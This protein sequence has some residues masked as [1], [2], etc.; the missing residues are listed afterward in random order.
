MAWQTATAEQPTIDNLILSWKEA[1]AQLDAVKAKEATI[2]A[3]LVAAAFPNAKEGVNT[4]ELGNGWQLKATVK[5]NYNLDKKN[6]D[7][8]IEKIEET[9]EDGKFV[10]ERLVTWKPELSIREYRQ[11]DPKHKVIIDEVLT[12]KEGAPT[13]ELV[14]P[15]A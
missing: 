9:G 14:E 2:R 1:K 11:L 6:T 3:A 8:A 7:N 5:Y 4:L 12:I 10:A 13:V 15:T